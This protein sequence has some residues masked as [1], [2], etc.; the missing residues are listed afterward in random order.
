MSESIHVIKSEADAYALLERI[1]NGPLP[2]GSRIKF[3]GWPKLEIRYKGDGYDSTITPAIMKG[4][5]EF[6]SALHKSYALA[7][8]NTTDTRKLTPTDKKNLE[9]LVKVEPG[10]SLFGI[11]FQSSLE[12]LMESVGGNMNSEDVLVLGIVIAAGYFGSTMFKAY[13]DHRKSV[14][15]SEAK[16]QEQV[17]VIKAMKDMS[18]E[19]T[20]RAEIMARIIKKYPQA[21]NAESYSYDAKNS[22][23]KTFKGAESV[24][25]QG[26]D[27]S[28]DQAEEIIKNA[29]RKS[30]EI[31]LDG[32]Y[33]ILMVDTTQIGGF[34]VKIRN[35]RS[36]EE[37]SAIVHD[38]TLDSRYKNL[39]QKAEWSKIPVQL[40]ISAKEI[41]GEVKNAEVLSAKAVEVESAPNEQ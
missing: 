6:Q 16:T 14:R 36:H 25:C 34:K 33:R 23:V 40:M 7:R 19:E 10:S 26:V 4:F 22:L 2:D 1:L 24:E 29:R 37:F 30:H 27:I 41:G 39:I 20:K 35:T 38:E 5:L 12:K 8:Y 21:Q 9:I 11:D 3:D 17:E 31:R 13:L 15:E 32:I 28:H 18:E